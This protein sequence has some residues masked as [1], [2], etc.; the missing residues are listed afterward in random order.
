MVA[1]IKQH[2]N[3]VKRHEA[4]QIRAHIPFSRRL[5]CKADK[6]KTDAVDAQH[7]R[8]V[9]RGLRLTKPKRMHL[10]RQNGRRGNAAFE[11]SKGDDVDS[12]P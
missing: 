5:L 6:A 7:Q 3:A 12:G 9:C 4:H 11:R 1:L 2:A 8:A 10:L